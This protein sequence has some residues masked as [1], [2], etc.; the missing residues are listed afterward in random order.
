MH[1]DTTLAIL[2][3]ETTDLGRQ[4]RDFENETCSVYKTHEL[5]REAAV[6]K[7]RQSKKGPT[8]GSSAMTDGQA[9]KQRRPKTLNLQT[10]KTHSLG[11]YVATIK[12]YGTTDSYTSAIVSSRISR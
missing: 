2:D 12:Q 3:Q 6:R 10:Y 4:L 7:R 1:T 5:K 9:A 8:A 11:D